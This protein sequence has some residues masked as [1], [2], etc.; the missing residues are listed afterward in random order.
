MVIITFGRINYYPIGNHWAVYRKI[1][2]QMR[3]RVVPTY[4]AIITKGPT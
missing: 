2:H 4:V 3:V 1:T